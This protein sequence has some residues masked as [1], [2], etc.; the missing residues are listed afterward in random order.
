MKRGYILFISAILLFFSQGIFA[1]P[2]VRTISGSPLQVHVGDDASFQ[3]FNSAVP[4]QGQIYPTGATGTADMGIFVRRAG[5]LFAPDFANHQGTATGGLG[6][7][8]PWT[9]VSISAVSGAG[10]AASPF[11]V[12]VVNDAAATG[13]RMTMTVTY[14]NGEN[15]FR[16][17]M[18]FSS[19]T[20][21][22]FD[23]FLGGDIY[24]AASDSGVP[25]TVSGSVGGQ[26]CATPPTYT[27]LFIPLTPA[28]RFAALAYSTIWSQ[29]GTGTLSNTVA[30]GCQD[31]GAALQWQ[32]RTIAAGGSVQI[33]AA[34]SFGA[35]PTNANF[36]VDSVTA[37][38]GQ[39][40]Q[41]L[42][43]TVT[44][45]GFQAG[46]TFSF[47]SGI[48]VNT[49]TI[50]SG[51]QATLTLSISGTATIGFRDVTGTQSAGGLVSTLT[52]GF[53][54]TGTVQPPPPPPP[55]TLSAIPTLA[56]WALYV[57]A[58]LLLMLGAGRILR[59]NDRS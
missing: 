5:T 26:D 18:T 37:N 10:T 17:A 59:P 25:F 23:A 27:I 42:T 38:Q 43:V 32:N 1:V 11:T 21:Q 46:T 36:R 45:V 47:G 50:N 39:P 44:G 14:V 51:T 6:T 54:V 33:Q 22:T 13:L 35:I 40:G 3:I 8:T 52:N 19:A 53:Q 24:L 58:F 4:G 56:D 29:I 16:K 31:N 55:V 9:P 12:V 48:T 20:A 34:T 7:Y 41:S 15:F 2:V 57:T 30:S 28:D 49:T